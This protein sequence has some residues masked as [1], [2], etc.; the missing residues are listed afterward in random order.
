MWNGTD[1]SYYNAS[2]TIT[3][4]CTVVDDTYPVWCQ[5][6]RQNNATNQ[7]IFRVTNN[8]TTVSRIQQIKTS[9]GW[10]ADATLY[11]GT[12]TDPLSNINVTTSY[13]IYRTDDLEQGEHNYLYCHLR[14]FNLSE[15]FQ[16]SG[17]ITFRNG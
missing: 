1:W 2:N 4:R 6:T 13:G 17:T 8:D 10:D 12:N 15:S 7:P 11:C 14:V 9:V 16:K 3:Y 5:P